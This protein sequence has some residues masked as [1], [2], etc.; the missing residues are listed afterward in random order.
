VPMSALRE[1]SALVQHAT[2]QVTQNPEAALR[3]VNEAAFRFPKGSLVAERELTALDALVALKRFAEAAERAKAFVAAH[4]DNE[5][6]DEVRR[7]WA[8]A[9]FALGQTSEACVVAKGITVDG[10]H[11]RCP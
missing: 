6:R 1:E 5:R 11:T 7:L 4:P 8:S 9:L 3:E 10:W 2:L